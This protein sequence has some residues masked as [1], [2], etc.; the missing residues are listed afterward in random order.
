[1]AGDRGVHAAYAIR[2]KHL[3]QI[4]IK[5]K[6]NQ[7]FLLYASAWELE[8]S[9]LVFASNPATPF[10]DE[11]L[12]VIGYC[13]WFE[14]DLIYVPSAV[15]LTLDQMLKKGYDVFVTK[16]SPGRQYRALTLSERSWLLLVGIH[17]DVIFSYGLKNQGYLQASSVTPYDLWVGIKLVVSLA[18]SLHPEYDRKRL[19]D[20]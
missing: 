7:D 4:L 20:Y 18:G 8:W 16:R 5:E 6:K 17:G 9:K 2:D 12:R 14:E 3:V 13:D 19:H 1:M 15:N 10:V 11:N